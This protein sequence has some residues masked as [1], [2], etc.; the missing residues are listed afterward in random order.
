MTSRELFVAKGHQLV[1]EKA[2]D[3]ELKET[4]LVN[5][6]TKDNTLRTS[7]VQEFDSD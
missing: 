2:E 3:N 5:E 6:T 4:K 7:D 1:S